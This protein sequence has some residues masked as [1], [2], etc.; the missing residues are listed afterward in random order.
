MQLKYVYNLTLSMKESVRLVVAARHCNP[1]KIMSHSGVV[2]HDMK[3]FKIE[4]DMSP[5][6]MD[7]F[8]KTN[9]LSE[10]YL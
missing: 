3:K 5:A 7:L 1:I 8:L 2:G 4:T 6:K 10:G 9:I